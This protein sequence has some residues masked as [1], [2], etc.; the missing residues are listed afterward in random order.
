MAIIKIIIIINVGKHV[1]KKE[2]LCTADGNVNWCSRYG[3]QYEGFS[4]IKN[5]TTI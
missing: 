3:N 4:K 2:P 1:E 5:R